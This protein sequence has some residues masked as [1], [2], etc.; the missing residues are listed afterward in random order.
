MSVPPHLPVAIRPV[1]DRT[2]P[3]TQVPEAISYLRE[4]PARGKIVITA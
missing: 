1:V 2:F 4:G 3:L